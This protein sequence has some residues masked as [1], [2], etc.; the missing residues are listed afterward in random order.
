MKFTL[1]FTLGLLLC[2]LPTYG[3]LNLADFEKMRTLLRED[4][5]SIVKEEIDASEKRVEKWIK[6]EIVASEKQM[7]EEITASEKRMKEFVAQEGYAVKG[8]MT[9][10]GKRVDMVFWLVTV[11]VGVV[12]VPQI[13][14]A[15]QQRKQREQDVKIEAL[16]KQI[17]TLQEAISDQNR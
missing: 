5:R 12:A 7:K 15:F 2:S 13:I 10:T 17:E 6:E 16:Q 4:I 9:E 14:V 8:I 11:L 3:E 1:I